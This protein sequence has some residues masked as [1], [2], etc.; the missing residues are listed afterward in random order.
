M[1]LFE[2]EL[3]KNNSYFVETPCLNEEVERIIAL[4]AEQREALMIYSPAPTGKNSAF[5]N[6]ISKKEGNKIFINFNDLT[7]MSSFPAYYIVS[8]IYEKLD[9]FGIPHQGDFPNTPPSDAG[10]DVETNLDVLLG[11]LKTD[12]YCLKLEKPLYI[13]ICNADMAF[14]NDFSLTFYRHFVF[15]RRRLPDNLHVFVITSSAK[16]VE[17]NK[18]FMTIQPLEGNVD[19]PKLF[20]KEL[21][22]KY[23]REAKDDLLLFANPSLR[24][25]DYIYIAAYAINYNGLKEYPYVIKELVKKNDTD[26]VL[27]FIF[28][29]FYSRLSKLGKA[30]FVE[31]LL[32]LYMFNFGITK[33]Q[34]VNSGKYL[35]DTDNNL[36]KDY[37]EISREEKELIL[38]SL[39]FFTKEEDDRLIIS[40]RFMREFIG[41]NA[42]YFTK[43]I[44]DIYKD[45][46]LAAVDHIFGEKDYIE[47]VRY[48]PYEYVGNQTYHLY[49]GVYLEKF[50]KENRFSKKNLARF[51]IFEPLAKRLEEYIKVYSDKLHSSAF[52]RKKIEPLEVLMI[53]YV[54]R[55]SI[56]YESTGDFG[57]FNHLFE[58]RDLFYMLVSKSRRLVKRVINRY[59]SM[60]MEFQKREYGGLDKTS[61]ATLLISLFPYLDKDDRYGSYREEIALLLGEVLYENDMLVNS[62]IKDAFMK[63]HASP[64]SDFVYVTGNEKVIEEVNALET[65][66]KQKELNF[67]SLSEDLRTFSKKYEDEENVFHKLIYAYLSFKTFTVLGE[68]RMVNRELSELLDP[69]VSDILIYS[70]YCYFPEMYGIIYA[71]F[72]RLYPQEYLHRMAVGADLLKAQGYNKSIELFVRALKYFSSLRIKEDK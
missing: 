1:D 16:Q 24:V 10:L 19:S 37:E 71:Y 28:N 58:Q 63:V 30:V 32:D 52:D 18:E 15:D 59:I 67:A 38:T 17:E 46:L 11:V 47:K 31:A 45:R 29:D 60:A 8:T 25:S 23:G 27:L 36:L 62:N 64:A 4:E 42:M 49:K 43:L 50:E 44:G 56:I 20:F 65:K 54:E 57:V 70:E 9:E 13:V 35:L 40:D 22:K 55:A 34:I 61:I 12:L 68:N 72:G 51:A 69:V 48:S 14:D 41:N 66:I 5:R 53:S 26:E 7:Y 33:D 6:A 39:S 21:L 3:L 2:K